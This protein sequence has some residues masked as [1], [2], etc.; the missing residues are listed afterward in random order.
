MGPAFFGVRGS[1]RWLFHEWVGLPIALL[2][3]VALLGRHLGPAHSVGLAVIAFVLFTRAVDQIEESVAHRASK[4]LPVWRGCEFT[5][6]GAILPSAGLPNWAGWA[7]VVVGL[8][9]QAAA[10]L[11]PEWPPARRRG[12]A[13]R[14]GGIGSSE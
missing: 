5:A 9:V 7:L 2:A 14:A 1:R 10:I 6:A 3:S 12:A 11:N 4:F 8:V 13:R